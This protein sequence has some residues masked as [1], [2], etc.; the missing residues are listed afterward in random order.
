MAAT[1]NWLSPEEIA[2]Y[3]AVPL[4]TVYGWNSKGT[5]PRF[6]KIGRHV[7]YSRADVEAWA[8]AQYEDR[9]ESA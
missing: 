2:T 9:P 5:G 1:K 8:A 4:G 3:F 7:R 6:A